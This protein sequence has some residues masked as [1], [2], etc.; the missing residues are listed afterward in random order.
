MDTR[1][2]LIELSTSPPALYLP[3]TEEEVRAFLRLPTLSPPDALGR[4]IE[5]LI[6]AATFVT[7]RYQGKDLIP[8][9]YRLTLEP[10]SGSVRLRRPVR[11]VDSVYAIE[12]DLS[13]TA[14]SSD[15]WQYDPLLQS[16]RF[17]EPQLR[18]AIDFTTS[19]GAVSE[20][21]KAGMLQLIG[22]WWNVRM[23]VIEA[24]E[25]RGAIELPN[26]LG[27]LLRFGAEPDGA[28][29]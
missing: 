16:V 13:L 6:A 27:A 21:V 15:K 7:E 9:S 19:A 28:I 8:R 22:L 3:L 5:L 29:I 24:N 11:S 26:T 4:Q 2:S 25:V 18:A 1:L 20:T 17:I 14:L 23:P 12:D 10:A